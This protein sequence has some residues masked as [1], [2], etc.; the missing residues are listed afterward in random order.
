MRSAFLLSALMLALP[1][2]VFAQ[3]ERP[4]CE[5]ERCAAQT[6]IDQQ[7][8]SCSEA[9]NHGAYVSCVARV[10]RQHVSPSCRGKAVRCAARST[11]GKS[12]F[13]TCEIP[14]DTCDLSAGSPGTCVGTPSTSCT[15]DFDCGTRCRIKSSDVRCT[16]AGGRVGASST[17][18]PACG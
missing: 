6:A 18:C 16:A 5:A 12:G 14:T 17:C 10:V 9:K 3:A 13:V 7:C 4:D 11:C 8:P 2:G 15:S 1:A